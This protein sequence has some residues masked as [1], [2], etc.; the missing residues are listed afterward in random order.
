[1][2]GGGNSEFT[3]PGLV[4][5]VAREIEGGEDV[6]VDDESVVL[7]GKLI[8]LEDEGL[9]SLGVHAAAGAA[10]GEADFVLP[11]DEFGVDVLFPIATGVGVGVADSRPHELGVAAQDGEAF[12]G[13]GN[14]AAEVKFLEVGHG[15][16]PGE[17]DIREGAVEVQVFK[18]LAVANPAALVVVSNAGRHGEALERLHLLDSAEA[19]AGVS[20]DGDVGA[21]AERIE[22]VC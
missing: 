20:V 10:T 19:L 17:A 11:R 15:R 13:D 16:E 5:F 8:S 4:G 22:V 9:G 21:E 12:F 3:P 2:D 6:R 7:D 14:G 1:M 18:A